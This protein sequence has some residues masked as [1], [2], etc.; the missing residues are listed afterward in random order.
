MII[1]VQQS[2]LRTKNKDN[3]TLW[4]KDR[5]VEKTAVATARR[6]GDCVS[7]ATNK[8][9]VTDAL[10]EAM[11]SIWSLPRLYKHVSS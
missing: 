1:K 2:L 4:L 9:A 7:A 3:V 11:F 10:F 8:H 6:C 5:I